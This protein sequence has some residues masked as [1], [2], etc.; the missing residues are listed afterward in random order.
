MHNITM[1][2]QVE[3]V[4]DLEIAELFEVIYTKYKYDFRDYSF[5]SM[6]RRVT[7]ALMG[8][9]L[10]S[11]AEL[12]SRILVDPSCFTDLLQFLTIPVSEMFRDPSYYRS[13]R[14]NV[15]P[16]LRTYP[17]LKIW[18]AGCST[19]EEVYSFA[20]L[21]KEAGLLERTIIYAT[22]INEVSL[23]K[24][25]AGIFKI[26]DMQ[27]Y[28]SNYQ[29]SGGEKEFSSYY[30]ADS[31]SAVFDSSLRKNI[32][33][34]DHSLATDHVF[35]EVQFISC[36]NV[37]IYFRRNLQERAIG[38]FHEA[39]SRKGFLGL[40]PKETVGL[41]KYSSGFEPVTMKDRLYQKICNE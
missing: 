36:R 19:G 15:V 32:T 1:N 10:V 6:G 7:Q 18:I 9:D 27:K 13:F 29:K 12:K 41:T 11:V 30:T 40:G 25:Q 39:L 5:A 2:P 16:V 8:L 28:T 35:S 24:A 23:K 37:L 17:S 22:D 31:E 14:D 26:K 20:I 33:F 3:N 38:L 21:L 4:V 34:N